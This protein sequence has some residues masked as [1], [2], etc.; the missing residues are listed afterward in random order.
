MRAAD[1]PSPAAAA[2]A[3]LS[4]EPAAVRDLRL[5]RFLGQRRRYVLDRRA[6]LRPGL[7]AAA[8]VLALLVLLNFALYVV[9]SMATQELTAGA[10]ELEAVLLA[11]D[12]AETALIAL[13]SVL[14]LVGVFLVTVL[15]THKTVG[16][17]YNLGRRLAE[18]AAGRY[19]VRVQLRRHDSLRALES[20]FN[21]MCRS[22]Q[23][24]AGEDA[25]A[26]D[27][28]AAEAERAGADAEGAAALARQL[29]LFADDKRRMAD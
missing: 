16:A 7:I 25:D 15:E 12:R 28:L 17:A 29:R 2:S 26:L 6:Q 24:R 10:P 5:G 22:L 11:Q 9:R 8:L 27:R 3:P 1:K 21:D 18:V 13:A 23:D 20:G 14:F 4:A 19:G